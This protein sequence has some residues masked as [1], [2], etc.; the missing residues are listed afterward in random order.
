MVLSFSLRKCGWSFS[1]LIEYGTLVYERE[2]HPSYHTT[3]CNQ[4]IV[5]EFF[6]IRVHGLCGISMQ[7]DATG[8]RT[9]WVS[10]EF[11]EFSFP[12]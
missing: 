6:G 3:R 12:L 8:L 9:S 5:S 10:I 4:I 2:T 11:G 7:P 1:V